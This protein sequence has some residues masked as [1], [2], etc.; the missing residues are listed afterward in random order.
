MRYDATMLDIGREKQVFVDDLLIESAEHICR[1]WHQPVRVSDSPVIVMDKPWEHIA[2]F[3][4]NGSQVVRD[5]EDGGLFKCVYHTW[6][7]SPRAGDS[8]LGTNIHNVLYAESEDGILWRKPE[9]DVHKVDGQ[10]TNVVIPNA[11]GVSYVLN[12]H[13]PDR[14]KRF[15]GLFLNYL[16]HKYEEPDW[17]GAA[18]SGDLVHWTWMQERPTFGRVGARMG[19]SNGLY[20]DPGGRL[21]VLNMRHYDIQAVPVNLN[22][23][24]LKAWSICPPYYPLDWSRAN[25]RRVWQAESSDLIHWSEPYSILTPEDGEDN[26]D[27]TFYGFCQFS[28]GGLRMGFLPI[29]HYVSNTM[30]V[31]LVYSRDGKMWHHLNKRQPFL[32]PRGEGHWDRY[33]VTISHGPIEVGDELYIYHGGAINHH[34]WW[35]TGEREDLQEPEVLDRKNVNYALGLVKLRLDGFASL[36]ARAPRRGILITRPLISDGTQLMVNARCQAGGSICAE[37]VNLRDEVFPGYSRE[38]CVVFQGDDVRHVFS[39]KGN[40]NLPPARTR[41]ADYPQPE[42]ERYRKI[43]FYVDRAELYSLTI[44]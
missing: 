8:P 29:L 15:K 5:P 16:P 27:E 20:Y 35:I 33:M 44:C 41:K 32:R 22:N 21:Y 43:R 25:K 9:L 4:F 24:M 38:D 17:V 40:S 39:W 6:E 23:P 34:D 3:T 11:L 26:L 19:D 14:A 30:D 36:D 10:L 31:R 7:H 12:P 28:V 18:T 2:Y 1:T 42:F 37:I 13:E